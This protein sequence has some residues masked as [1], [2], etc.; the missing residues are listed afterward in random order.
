M[1]RVPYLKS[2]NNAQTVPAVSFEGALALVFIVLKLT[3]V[4]D[5]KWVWV[6]SPFWV[7]LVVFV[8]FFGV[9]VLVA[10][11]QVIYE[12]AQKRKGDYES[13]NKKAGRKG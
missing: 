1:S 11:M 3:G 8:L 2:N 6:L 5:W 12:H 10:A 4:I 13:K 7:P 9:V